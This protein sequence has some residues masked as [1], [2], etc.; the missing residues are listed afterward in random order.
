MHSRI[1]Q[2]LNVMPHLEA[3][4]KP[5]PPDIKAGNICTGIEYQSSASLGTE[6]AVLVSEHV[7]FHH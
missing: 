7:Q 6:Y 5:F 4:R 2:G 1:R 3:E